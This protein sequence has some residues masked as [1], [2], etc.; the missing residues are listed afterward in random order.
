[1]MQFLNT[2]LYILSSL[3]STQR[4]IPTSRQQI[5]TKLNSSFVILGRA[6][7]QA[8]KNKVGDYC[9][10]CKQ[11]PFPETRKSGPSFARLRN[12][13]LPLLCYCKTRLVISFRLVLLPLPDAFCFECVRRTLKRR[14]GTKDIEGKLFLPSATAVYKIQLDAG[15]PRISLIAKFPTYTRVNASAYLAVK[16]Q[17]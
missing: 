15:I 11:Q 14:F 6:P 2:C 5:K 7:F 4:L 9:G 17:G 16:P 1:M 12:S 10:C 13:Q 8:A 3:L